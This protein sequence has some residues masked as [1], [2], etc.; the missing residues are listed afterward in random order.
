MVKKN[1]PSLSVKIGN[2]DL[3]NPVMVAS[4]KFGNAEEFEDL[5]DVR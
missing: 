3:K 5:M 4:G 2:L 1:K